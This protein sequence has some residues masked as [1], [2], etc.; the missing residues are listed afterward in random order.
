MLFSSS[1][2]RFSANKL[3]KKNTANNSTCAQAKIKLF[4]LQHGVLYVGKVLFAVYEW[5]WK[6]KKTTMAVFNNKVLNN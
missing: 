1:V 3:K 4:A 6:I 5:S 2:E